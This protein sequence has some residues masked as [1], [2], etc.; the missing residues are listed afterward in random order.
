MKKEIDCLLIGHNELDVIE[1]EAL[2]KDTLG[3]QSG[4]YRSL[5]LDYFKHQDRPFLV[6]DAL[7]RLFSGDNQKSRGKMIGLNDVLSAAVA[8]LATYLH[9]RGFHFDYINSFQDEKKQLEEKLT[10]NSIVTIA[11]TTTL[12]ITPLPILEIIRFIKKYNNE[13]KIV[14]G[15]PFVASQVRRLDPLKLHY[16]FESIIGADFYVISSQGEATLVKIID[17]L[18]RNLPLENIPNIYYR[19]GDRYLKNPMVRENNPLSENM[20]GWE[21]FSEKIGESVNLRTSISCPFSCAFCSFPEHAGK[22]QT[23]EVA[24]VE[25]E[26]DELNRIES[27]KFINI[28]DDTFNVPKK[29]FKELLSMMI[30]K[31]YKFKW[32]SHFRCQLADREMVRLMKESGCDSVFLGLESGNNQIL[33]N[34][35]KNAQVEKYLEGIALLKEYDIVTYG[36]FIVGFPGETH[37]TVQ[38]TIDLIR[39]SKI[40]FYRVYQWYCDPLTPIWKQKD[41]YKI[42]GSEFEWSHSTMDSSTA[43]DLI[44]KMFLDITDSIWV[45]L[46]NFA[47]DNLSSLRSHNIPFD[48]FKNILRIYNEGIRGKFVDPLRGEVSPRIIEKL[49]E[50]CEIR[51]FSYLRLY[52]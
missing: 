45:P 51:N 52:A 24:A 23:A 39:Q 32:H 3:V 34:M 18:K 44:D 11:I 33:K 1:N 40:D 46:F 13:A 29:R 10:K 41:K 27:V 37:E 31:D 43:C 8:Y 9:R 49:R 15:G 50:S 36:S 42:E 25:K 7:S 47:F 16:L 21:L 19:S 5:S 38:D 20:V 48:Q 17:S 4:A 30:K 6:A 26:F 2:V 35:N 12:Y 28:I 14:V 22:Y